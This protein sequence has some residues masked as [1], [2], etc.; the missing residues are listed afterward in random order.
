MYRCTGRS[1]VAMGD[2]VGRPQ[3][4]RELAWSFREQADRY[5]AWTVFYEVGQEHLDLYLDL[6][7]T[8]LKLGEEA[9]V[10]LGE[11]SLEGSARRGLRYT[12]RKVEA[13]GASFEVAPVEA[14]P[15]LLPELKKISDHWLQQKNTQK[16]FSGQFSGGHLRRFRSGWCAPAA[17]SWPSPTF[18]R[19][20]IARSSPST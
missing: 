15:A 19:A 17:A 11:F 10:P 16:S 3:E 18:G 1:W 9:R 8:L 12:V 14:M 2:P 6:G 7:L 4:W 5:G 20:T 13:D